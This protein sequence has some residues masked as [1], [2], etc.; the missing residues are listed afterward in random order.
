MSTHALITFTVSPSS[1]D[2]LREKFDKVTYLPPSEDNRIS[3]IL[4]ALQTAQVFLVTSGDLKTLPA[5][6]EALNRVG[7]ALRVVQLGSAGAD[8]ALKTDWVKGMVESGR[9]ARNEDDWRG[10]NAEE[11]E[12]DG[13]KS[14]CPPVL[15]RAAHT[16]E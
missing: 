14:F 13:R 3:R 2:L 5:D 9:M 8:A 10:G 4:E 6:E 1:L 11:E 12:G 7:K 15:D 16:L